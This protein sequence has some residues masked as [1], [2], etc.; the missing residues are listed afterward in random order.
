MN[1]SVI[2][3]TYNQPRWLELAL[4]GYAVQTDRD[5]E[6]IIADDG[7]RPETAAVVQRMQRETGLD[8]VHVWHEDRGFRKCEILNR[9]IEQSRGDY[10]LF[11]DGDCVP[12][13]DLL[14]VHREQ[15]EPGRFLAGGY[16]KLSEAVSQSVTRT[17][18]EQGYVSDLRWLRSQG[19]RPGR[20][21]L[22]LT[23][24]GRFAALLDAVT[25]TAARFQG[26][27]ASVAREALYAVNGFEGEMGYGGEDVALGRRLEMLGVRGKQIRHR[28]IC[29]HL[30]HSRPYRD[31]AVLRANRA[32]YQRMQAEGEFRARRG[33]AELPQDP[34][35]A[36]WRLAGASERSV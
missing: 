1:I 32:W 15:A 20:R 31:P 13:R 2:L 33:I 4:W 9:A 14:A 34:T 12:R 8:V 16:L 11:S 19:W 25:P 30:H 21:A 18:V 10:L 29:M 5:F 24:S 23:R 26:N 6:L 17:A 27:N 22:R 35:L 7:S 28:A 3:S 36:V